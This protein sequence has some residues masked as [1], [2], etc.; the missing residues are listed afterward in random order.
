MTPATTPTLAATA[1]AAAKAVTY[2]PVAVISGVESCDI[3]FGTVTAEGTGI[4]HARNGTAKC[5]DTVNDPRMNG[6]YA[7]TWNLD[8]WGTPDHMNGALV[9]WGTARLTV[10]GGTWEGRASGV[11]SSDRGDTIVWWWTGTGGNAGLTCFELVT[12]TG[13]WMIQGEIFPGAP[14]KP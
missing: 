3:D 1:T 10:A 9:Q 4:Q 7:A 14:P 6:T 11:Y 13:P 2:G 12:G 5:T 8:Y